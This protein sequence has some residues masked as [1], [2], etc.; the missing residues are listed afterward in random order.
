MD[1][2]RAVAMLLH[3]AIED[4]GSLLVLGSPR[5]PAA[6]LRT[7]RQQL[8]GAF[9]PAAIVPR[10]APPGYSELLDAADLLFVTADS[11]AMI[12]EAVASGK[13]VGLVPIRPSRSGSLWM[14]LMDRLRPGRRLFPRDLRFVW[15]ALAHQGYAGTLEQPLRATLPDFAGQVATMIRDLMDLPVP[16]APDRRAA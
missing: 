11:V 6:V 16:P 7:V 15:S 2:E 10:D 5:T 3:R 1:I 8:A 4:G 12:S 14:A 9:A 13:P